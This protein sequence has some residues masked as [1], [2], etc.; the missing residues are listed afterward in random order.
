VERDGS[1]PAGT[2]I[3]VTE[4]ATRLPAP[5]PCDIYDTESEFADGKTWQTWRELVAGLRRVQVRVVKHP[6]FM[7][8]LL[9]IMDKSDEDDFIEFHF[10]PDATVT[11]SLKCWKAAYVSSS[12]TTPS[13]TSYSRA[14]VAGITRRFVVEHDIS[15]PAATALDLTERATRLLASPD[16]P[17]ARA[18]C[19]AL[20]LKNEKTWQ[21]WL[22][23]AAGLRRVSAFVSRLDGHRFMK[24]EN[25]IVE[26]QISA[27]ATNDFI[28]FKF[29]PVTDGRDEWSLKCWGAGVVL[30]T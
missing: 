21:T 8:V 22:E 24:N 25:G 13:R 12:R 19:G 30:I 2:A 5:S 14:T 26:V 17:A 27:T 3:D 6:G 23:L 10:E 1:V 18:P 11:W 29:E 28:S 15:I 7:N 20:D 9:W 16:P 4:R